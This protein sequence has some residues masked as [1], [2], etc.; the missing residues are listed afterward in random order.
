MKLRK[1]IL[2]LLLAWLVLSA[3]AAERGPWSAEEIEFFEKKVRPVLV[4]RCYECH[5][6]EKQKGG[7]RLDSRSGVLSGGDTGPALV[8]GKPEESLLVKAISY[9]DP[10]FQMPPKNPLPKAESEA[11]RDWVKRGAPDPR[12]EQI[13]S[14]KDSVTTR[15]ED[16]WSYQPPRKSSPAVSPSG[17]A[18]GSIDQYIEEGFEKKGVKP[19]DDADPAALLRRVYFDLI[20]LPPSAEEISEFTREPSAEA[21]ERVVDRLL[22]SPQFGERWARHWLDVARFAESVTLRGFVFEHAWRYRDYVIEAFNSDLPYD[23]FI[24]EQIA[25]DLLEC[26]TL[27]ERQR[28]RVATTFLVLGNINYEEQDKAQLRM[29]IVDE[30]LDTIGKTFLAQ[31]IGC[32]R[33]HDHKFDPIPTKD[34]YAMA[35]ILRNTK[36]VEHANVS[37]WMEV[38][39]PLTPE[40]EASFKEQE[41]LTAKLQ[42]QIK[43]RKGELGKSSGG[44]SSEGAID[45]KKLPG[46]VIDDKDARRVGEWQHSTYTGKFVGLGYLH[47][48]ADGKGSKTLTFLPELSRSGKYEVRLAYVPSN[49]RAAN[50]P[51]T[52]LH[53]G[54]ETIVRVDQRATPP[55][56]ERF[57]VLGQ[58]EFEKGNQGYVLIS[59]EGTREHVIADA[60]QFIPVAE[61]NQLAEVGKGD[62]GDAQKEERAKLAA[63]IKELEAELKQVSESGPAR[64]MVMSVLEEKVIEDTHVHIR[65]SV[66]S[67]GEEVPRG[68]LQAAGGGESMILPNDQSGR[69]ELA[70]WIA[71]AQNP[72]TARV[73][74]NRVWHWLFG[75]G[76]VGTPDNFGTTGAR[77]SHPEL[78]DYLALRFVEEG[79][80]MKELIREIVLSRTYRLSSEAPQELLEADPENRL[81]ARAERRRL[82]P[83][84]LRDT[85]LLLSGKL[86]L[87]GGGATYRSGLKADYG[88]VDESTRRSVYV[89]V[90][91]NALPE[92]FELFDFA[93]PSM[94]TGQRNVSTVAPQAL[95]FLNHPFVIENARLTA[96]RLLEKGGAEETRLREFYLEAIGRPPTPNEEAV[97]REFLALAGEKEFGP[98]QAWAEL[99]QAVFASMDFRYLK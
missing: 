84:A 71:S 76:I 18:K 38:P 17:W 57:M 2:L 90:F 82:G 23:R 48:L 70:E 43:A 6:A 59:N 12:L 89:P 51:V 87:E 27:E 35:G 28:G 47:D 62:E 3:G 68:F 44:K 88:Y 26:S 9:E 1:C 14:E 40:R 25:G 13:A 56:D 15:G 65:G 45:P 32:A 94:V 21:L 16:H 83:E 93:D 24:R 66:H 42:E 61:L 77:P 19:A 80:S 63:E 74:A 73:M 52:I 39:L 97:A 10:D 78:L 7:L 5:G 92:I 99:C 69:R 31:T 72:L 95:Y 33:C 85:I 58:F 91:R 98:E 54:G 22:A 60:V 36:S 34:Y 86:S 49:N 53:A 8:P 46:I 37:N 81:F 96:E 50:V 11:L 64:P 67:L 79:W 20:G 30:Q 41:A 4:N 75:K 55:I 29:D